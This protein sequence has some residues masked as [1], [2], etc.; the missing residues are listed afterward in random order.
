MLRQAED[1]NMDNARTTAKRQRQIRGRKKI[2]NVSDR[3]RLSVYRSNS[4]IYAQVI[5]HNGDTLVGVSEKSLKIGSKGT[6]IERA[7]QVGIAIAKAAKE[8]KIND[9]VFDKGSFAYHG[10]VKAVAEGAREGGLN[11]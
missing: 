9:V 6:P 1:K 2:S 10:R 7:K 11:V 4:Y 8:K 3:M 5:D